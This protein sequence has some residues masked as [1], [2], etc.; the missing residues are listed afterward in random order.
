[1][2]SIVILAILFLTSKVYSKDEWLCTEEAS[3]RSGS[4]LTVCGVGTGDTEAD[5]RINA[6]KEAKKEFEGVCAESSDCRDHELISTPLRNSCDQTN[7]NKWK[8]YRAFKYEITSTFRSSA[9][10]EQQKTMLD[11]EIRLNEEKVQ[12]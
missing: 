6:L 10:L 11:E 1:M 2:R 7:K 8:C 3:V 5:A 4:E 12:K 9:Y